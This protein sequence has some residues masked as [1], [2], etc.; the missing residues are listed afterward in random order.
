MIMSAPEEDLLFPPPPPN[1][2]PVD[3]TGEGK[4]SDLKSHNFEAEL[5]FPGEWGI[6]FFFSCGQIF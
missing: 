6:S 2:R 3:F 4:G 5:K 1:G